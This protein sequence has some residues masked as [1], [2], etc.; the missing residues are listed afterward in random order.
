M[1]AAANTFTVRVKNMAGEI[2]SIDGMDGRDYVLR[3]KNKI[4]NKLGKKI[5]IVIRLTYLDNTPQGFTE[6]IDFTTL[7]SYP[8]DYT[9]D[10]LNLFIQSNIITHPI[11]SNEKLKWQ[12]KD[13]ALMEPIPSGTTV[14]HSITDDMVGKIIYILADPNAENGIRCAIVKIDVHPRSLRPLIQIEVIKEEEILTV[15]VA[16]NNQITKALQN[17]RVRLLDDSAEGG[18][19]KKRARKRTLCRR[20]RTHCKHRTIFRQ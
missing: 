14:I 5:N 18:R 3:L 9:N 2:L 19:R 13:S 16:G 15:M 10:I 6:L 8:I 4:I 12:L 7:N 17:N 11:S 1:A 20:R